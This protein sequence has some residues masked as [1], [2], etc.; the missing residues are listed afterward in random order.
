MIARP[1]KIWFFKILLL[2]L[3]I[4]LKKQQKVLHALSRSSWLIA[5][6]FEFYKILELIS[7]DF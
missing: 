2:T 7:L 1:I 5:K 4:D 6:Y 3:H